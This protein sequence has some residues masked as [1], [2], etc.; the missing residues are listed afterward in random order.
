METF[1]LFQ[2]LGLALAIGLVIGLERGWRERQD[3]N[4]TAGLRTHALSGLLGGVWGA[5]TTA[6]GQSAGLAL[7]LAFLTFAGA[8]TLFRYRETQQEGTVGATTVV[9]AML[10]F[11]LGAYA[12]L[13]DM[14]AAAAAGVAVTALLALKAP[15][16]GWVKNLTWPELRSALTLLAMSFI[17]L[18][19]LPD[20]TI[21]PLEAINPREI[22]LMVIM[23]A[24]VSFIG[25]V[26]VRLAGERAGIVIAGIAGGLASSTAVTLT[27]ARLAREHPDQTRLAT[28]GA[29]FAGATMTARI[30]AV[31][32]VFNPAMLLRLAFPLVPAGLTLLAFAVFLLMFRGKADEGDRP[33]ELRNPFE[34]ATVLKFGALLVVVMLL[35]EAATRWAGGAGAYVLAAVSGLADVDAITLSMA[36]LG[37]GE[38]AIATAA[39]AIAIAA[40]VNTVT[41]AVLAWTSGGA[42]PGRWMAFASACALA[43]G[44]AGALV[45]P[46]S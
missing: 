32:G 15:L 37:R 5:L 7:G 23:I 45:A 10:A 41:K 36:R 6:L 24:L 42:G 27:M 29:L 17:L 39:N 31:V 19:V 43:A 25:Y 9:A 2:R 18:P 22:W 16:H 11:A 4:H 35:G 40:G 44:V 12:V 3:A 1:E 14:Q 38:L 20:R 26:A 30:L 8:I 33:L 21:D 28:A 46:S 34:L 13:G